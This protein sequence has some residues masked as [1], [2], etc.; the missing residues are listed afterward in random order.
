MSSAKRGGRRS[1]KSAQGPTYDQ[2][3]AE[4]E[5]RGVHGRLD[6]DRQWLRRALGDKD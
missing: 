5:R 4:A 3:H 1:P 6:M 2:L